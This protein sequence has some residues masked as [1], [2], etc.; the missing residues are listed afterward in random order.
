MNWILE[1]WIEVI[2]AL[3]G[4]IYIFL[5][6]KEDKLM[7]PV[8]IITSVF[9]IIIFFNSK[10]YAD[11]GLQ[12]YYVLISIYG[13]YW[14]VYGAKKSNSKE[15]PITKLDLKLGLTLLAISSLIFIIIGYYLDNYTDSNIPY[16][17][18]FTTALS[19][20]A[21]WMLTRKII[22][23][24][25]VWIIVNIVSSGLYIYKELYITVALYFVFLVLAFVGYYQWKKKLSR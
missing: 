22:E 18:A 11:M 24:W 8:G 16:W 4:F 21:T 7:W 6:I 3:A 17:D 19:I 10:L 13:W 5:E 2:G 14:W 20:T 23:Q 1:N 25:L 15:L 12:F 9:Y